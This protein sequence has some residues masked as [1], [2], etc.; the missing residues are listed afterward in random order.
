V[1]KR[2]SGDSY[3]AKTCSSQI[4]RRRPTSGPHNSWS[5]TRID[6]WTLLTPRLSRSPRSATSNAS[7]RSTPTSTSTGYTEVNTSRSCRCELGLAEASVLTRSFGRSSE[8]ERSSCVRSE[9]R[10]ARIAQSIDSRGNCF[11]NAVAESFFATLKKELIH[12]RA[13]PAKAELRS[14]VLSISRS[15][16]IVSGATRVSGNSLQAS[17]RGSHTHTSSAGKGRIV[18]RDLPN[19]GNSTRSP[20]QDV[21]A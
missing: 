17:T 8:P 19:Q 9:G 2:P 7:S 13:W 12:H 15:S 4:R 1:A 20:R 3:C 10:A 21:S 18:N 6:R 14:E 11:D 5:A 16:T